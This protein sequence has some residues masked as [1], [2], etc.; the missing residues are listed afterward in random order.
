MQELA[1][2]GLVERFDDSM[3]TAEHFLQPSFPDLDLSYVAQNVDPARRGTLAERLETMREEC[4]P[5]L[6]AQLEQLNELDLQLVAATEVEL[7]RRLQFV[8]DPSRQRDNFR[9]AVRRVEDALRQ[10]PPEVGSVAGGRD[11]TCRVGRAE[12]APTGT[13]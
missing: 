11:G 5:R 1:V 3:V 10:E 6:F 2:V 12:R 9:G 7:D 13:N 4:G 8:P